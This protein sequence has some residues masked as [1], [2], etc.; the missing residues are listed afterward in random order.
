M[1]KTNSASKCIM[2]ICTIPQGHSL[3]HLESS[4]PQHQG[5]RHPLRRARKLSF[6]DLDIL[7][8]MDLSNTVD[9]IRGSNSTNNILDTKKVAPCSEPMEGDVA[10]DIDETNEG[11][12]V[13]DSGAD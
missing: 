3:Y 10:E 12:H 5:Y 6:L 4:A 9:T 1:S 13:G 7:L 11:H 8:A 2:K